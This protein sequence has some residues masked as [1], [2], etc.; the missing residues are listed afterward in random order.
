M[1]HK[2]QLYPCLHLSWSDFRLSIYSRL[3]FTCVVS[4]PLFYS[5][6]SP[7]LPSPFFP[8]LSYVSSTFSSRL[9][10]FFF[11]S[12]LFFS[13]LLIF[14]RIVSSSLLSSTL[15]SYAFL[16]SPTPSHSRLFVLSR[17]TWSPLPQS[18]LS[19]LMRIGEVEATEDERRVQ[20]NVQILQKRKTEF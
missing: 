14:S 1:E 16:S 13:S 12:Y 3:P 19:A 7:P 5:R 2:I 4:P 6:R 15:L 18:A 8:I 11:F 17:I 10:Y 20:Q 9:V